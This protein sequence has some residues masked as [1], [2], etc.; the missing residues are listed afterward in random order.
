MVLQTRDFNNILAKSPIGLTFLAA[1]SAIN[2]PIKYSPIFLYGKAAVEKDYL[3]KAIADK[4]QQTHERPA[5][6]VTVKQF[7]NDFVR[8]VGEN[9]KEL[10]DQKYKSNGLLIIDGIQF[11]AGKPRTQ[12]ELLIMLKEFQTQDRQIILTADR[13]PYFIKE[14]NGDLK[15]FCQGGL[16][17]GIE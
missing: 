12:Q 11:L 10:F 8:S 14:L 13:H 15:D 5:L 4:F 9:K 6:Y 16:L 3:F 1:S 7:V 2:E 17:L